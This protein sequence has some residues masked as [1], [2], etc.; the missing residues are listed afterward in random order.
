MT[1]KIVLIIQARTGSTRFPEKVLKLIQKKSMIWHVINR[2]KQIPKIDVIVLA[3]TK[4][5]EDLVLVNIAK[6]N[7]IQYFQGKTHNVLDR[8]FQCAK[9]F[10][11]DIIIRITSDCPLIDPKLIQQMLHVYLNH[12]YDYLS[13]T[14]KPTFPDG[15]DVEIFSF[16]ALEQ[17]FHSAKWK[18]EIE[19]VT[20]Y[21]KKNSKIFKIFNYENKK[22]FSNIR[23][24][25]DE[26]LDLKLIRK[27]YKKFRPKLIFSLN[28][29]IKIISNDPNFFLI[30]RDLERD[31]GYKKSLQYDKQ[32]R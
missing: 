24:T 29:I 11:A 27:I 19:H 6:N 3:T 1:K 26:P 14:I 9:K 10:N 28:D 21:I 12:D 30:N 18:S 20:P 22:N 16:Q 17:A 5:K 13:N 23:L 15:L 32:I 8:F 2:V 7:D 31:A 4:K 25:V